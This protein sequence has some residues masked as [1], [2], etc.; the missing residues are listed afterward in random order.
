[1]TRMPDR[2]L[3]ALALAAVIAAPA[4]AQTA[5]N[6]PAPQAAAL[7]PLAPPAASNFTVSDIRVDGLQRIGAGTVFTYLPVERGDTVNPTRV[8][9]AVRALYRTGF[10]EDIQVA[11]QGD[12][13][14]FT[15]TERP[16]INR[17]TLTGNKDIKTEDLTKGLNDIGLSEGETFDRL[18]LDRVTQELVRQYNNRGKYNVK[19][20]PTVSRL[21]RNRVDIAINIEEGKAAKIRHINIV[22]NEVYDLETLTDN[23][24]SGESNWLSWYRRDDQY[25]REKLEGDREKLHNFYLDRG[26]IDF[27]ED[28][29]QVSI[30]PDKADM[31]ITAGITEGEIYKVS[32]VQ[33]TGNTVLPKEEIESRVFVKEDQVFSRALLELSSDAITATLGNI[34]YAFAQVNPIPEVDRENRTV[35]INLQVVPGPRV[36]VRRIQFKGNNRTSDEVIRREMRQF[37]GSWYSQAAIDR[38]KVRLQRLGYF[39]SGSVN[40]ET[41]PVPGSNDEVDV[42]FN[43]T[44]TTSGSF[45]F[46]LGYS[47]LAGVTTS[48][49]LSQNNFLGSGNRV[50][51]EAQRNVYLQ[52]Y[53]FS[54]MNPYFTDG[55]MSLGYNLWWR[56]FDNS[57]FNTAQYSSTSAAGQAILGIPLTENDSISLLFG[58]DRNQIFAWRGSSPESIVDYID[59]F[60]SRTFHAWRSELAWARDTRNDYLQPTRGMMQRVSLETTLPGSTAEYFKLNYEI[61]KYWPINRHLVLNTRAEIGYGDSY[62]DDVVRNICYTAST[63]ANPNPTPSSPCEPSSPDYVRTVTGGGLPFFEN[64]YAGGARSVRGFRDNTLGPRE[65]AFA[66]SYL[67]PIGGAVKTVGSFEMFFPQLIKSPAARISAFVD[68]GNVFSDVDSW[69]A[70][71]LRASAGVALMWRAPVGPISISY[72]YPLRSQDEVRGGS[73]ELIRGGDELERLQFT[74]GGA[75]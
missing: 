18:D 62:G 27:S 66:S 6:A 2:R 61:S 21:D 10:F 29:I 15:V 13:L 3:L 30:S 67:Q 35:A 57:E 1:M 19:I 26:Y 42:V 60:G 41:Q 16:A 8:S 47:Q 44:E 53:S 14:V 43:M 50:S 36:Q 51:V 12:I 55:G 40:V 24:E 34:G 25:S 64:F 31:F 7:P 22:G 33:I 73:G 63:E 20:T 72:A 56:E 75:F 9:E 46:G 48:V 45:V 4:W 59:A 70:K 58:A 68:F 52:R 28:S 23:W 32:D 74:F 5:A 38:S 39:E 69:E 54:F 65:T 37:E 71:E 11:R 49:Q 17:L